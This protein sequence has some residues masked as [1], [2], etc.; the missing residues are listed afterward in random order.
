M[1]P[2]AVP[3]NMTQQYSLGIS[4]AANTQDKLGVNTRNKG[5]NKAQKPTQAIDDDNG[6]D[7]VSKIAFYDDEFIGHLIFW[8][9]IKKDER[10]FY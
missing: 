7:Q 9:R 3:A 10:T 8:T 6:S 4:E 2:K 5:N 1:P